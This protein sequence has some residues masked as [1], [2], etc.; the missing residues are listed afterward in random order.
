MFCASAVFC[1]DGHPQDLV[2]LLGLTQYINNNK[3]ESSDKTAVGI[4]HFNK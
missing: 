2:A 1:A 3:K 4:E